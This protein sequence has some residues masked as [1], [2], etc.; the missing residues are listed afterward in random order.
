MNHLWD[1][2]FS[3]VSGYM[4][5]EQPN[6]WIASAL[7]KLSQGAKVLALADGEGRNAVWLAEQGYQV[8]NCDYSAVGL[9]KTQKLASQRGV[10][11]DTH[12]VD[13]INHALPE[14]HFD[15]VVA[16]FFHLP[17]ANQASVWRNVIAAIKPNGYLVV[18]VFSLDQLPLNSGGPKDPDL[19]YRLEDWRAFLQAMRI[20]TLEAAETQLDEGEFHQGVANV[21]NIKS[22]K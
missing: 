4:Y 21:I 19:L 11:V 1:Q 13:L 8:I 5:G 20:D 18:Q 2:R 12:C 9:E 22:V 14:C 7:P 3:R 15:A 10:N 17:R 6:A 16:S